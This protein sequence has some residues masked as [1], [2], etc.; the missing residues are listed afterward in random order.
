MHLR[1]WTWEELERNWENRD[2]CLER[3]LGEEF[4][5]VWFIGAFL[6]NS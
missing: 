5:D 2:S 1:S 6:Y 4:M 3:D